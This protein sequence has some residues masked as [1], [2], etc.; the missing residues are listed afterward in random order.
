MERIRPSSTPISSRKTRRSGAAE[1]FSKGEAA[2]TLYEK[3]SDRK[4]YTSCIDRADDAVEF[5]RYI[6]WLCMTYAGHMT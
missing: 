1:R 3:H 2:P 6:T 4:F 5:L